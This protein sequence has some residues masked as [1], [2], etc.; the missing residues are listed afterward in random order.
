MVPALS[1]KGLVM[2]RA[3]VVSLVSKSA[4]LLTDAFPFSAV[5]TPKGIFL[6]IVRLM[7]EFETVSRWQDPPDC[8][9]LLFFCL[10]GLKESILTNLNA[11]FA[12]RDGHD[13]ETY[14]KCPY[15]G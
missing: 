10:T 3:M 14:L 4:D 13:G 2:S 8:L 6:L 11:F 7:Q 9:V 5:T 1:L 12:F 15:N